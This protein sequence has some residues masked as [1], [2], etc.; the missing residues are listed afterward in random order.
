MN[1]EQDKEIIKKKKKKKKKET[2][3]KRNSILDLQMLTIDPS[4]LEGVKTRRT[5]APQK[6]NAEADNRYLNI[7]WLSN[8]SRWIG[9]N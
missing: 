7:D 3:R 4:R 9:V 1:L 2:K 8:C 5:K 6:S